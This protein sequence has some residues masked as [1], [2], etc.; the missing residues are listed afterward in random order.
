MS[1]SIERPVVR[2]A[3]PAKREKLVEVAGGCGDADA[4]LAN[5][6][7]CVTGPDH[8][9]ACS[10]LVGAH[11]HTVFSARKR[12]ERCLGG[13][14]GRVLAEGERHSKQDTGA[15]RRG[16]AVSL[17]V[18]IKPPFARY[19]AK[20]RL[21]PTIAG[22]LP[23]HRVYVEAY[24][25]SAAVLLAKWPSRLEVLNDR[26]VDVVVF[27]RV[28]RERADELQ[29]AL[30]LT[31]YSEAEFEACSL[32]ADDEV[33][34]ARRFFV[35]SCQS[36]NGKGVSW[37]R[38]RRQDV[39]RSVATARRVDRLWQVA[40]RLRTVQIEQRDAVDVIRAYDAEDCVM[41]IDPPYFGR[42]SVSTADYRH[43][44]PAE[45]EHRKLANVLNGCRATVFLSG[46]ASPLYEDLYAGWSRY[47]RAVQRLSSQQ[48]V[49]DG[50]H[51]ATEV[52]WSN[53]PIVSEGS[54]R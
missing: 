21:A 16:R 37:A 51:H 34:Q 28:L 42:A 45:A 46:Y 6:T 7:N 33:E 13:A 36:I 25:G 47:A 31:P 3:I 10:C 20:A 15:S 26:D 4:Q 52:I 18:L 17:P 38:S 1:G 35:R 8:G 14:E 2:P 19:G 48:R 22:L 54:E 30:E 5:E 11:E 49:G 41:Y 27:L 12:Y 40:E 53:R 39:P 50:E 44:M 43:D 24:G 23:P 32:P 29:R 9:H